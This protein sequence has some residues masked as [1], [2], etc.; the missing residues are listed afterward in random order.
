MK[1][2]KGKA[3]S[4]SR[5]RRKVR[6]EKA[7]SEEEEILMG[8]DYAEGSKGRHVVTGDVSFSLP[9]KTSKFRNGIPVYDDR[10][11]KATCKLSVTTWKQQ[12]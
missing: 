9:N 6:S 7:E 2:T 3:S 5:R 12:G 10:R 11:I 8:E 4:R 1:R